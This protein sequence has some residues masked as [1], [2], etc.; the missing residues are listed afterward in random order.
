MHL[1]F[2]NFE[3]L[4]FD[5]FLNIIFSQYNYICLFIVGTLICLLW[6]MESTGFLYSNKFKRF[7]NDLHEIIVTFLIN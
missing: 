2:N 1:V 5:S 4:K 7:A 3:I 6:I